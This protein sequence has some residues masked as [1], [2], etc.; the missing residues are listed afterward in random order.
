LTTAE[1][2]SILGVMKNAMQSATA[3]IHHDS[4][5]PCGAICARYVGER[6]TT[7][8]FPGTVR[9]IYS[10]S[11]DFGVAHGMVEV[12]LGSGP[13]CVDATSCKPSVMEQE[14]GG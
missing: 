14:V 7:S 8:G 2:G 3:C 12:Q 5:V 4:T 13:V 10:R 11:V 6:V 1:I 9:T